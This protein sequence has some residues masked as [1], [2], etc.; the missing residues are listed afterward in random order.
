MKALV[1]VVGAFL[2]FAEQCVWEHSADVHGC[3]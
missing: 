2:L 3:A 1:V